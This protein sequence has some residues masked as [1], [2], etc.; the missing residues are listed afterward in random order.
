MLGRR[1]AED[2]RRFSLMEVEDV[3]VQRIER[4]DGAFGKRCTSSS[5]RRRPSER[6]DESAAALGAEVDREEFLGGP[7][8]EFRIAKCV[9]C[10]MPTAL[11]GHASVRHVRL[12]ATGMRSFIPDRD[13]ATHA[14]A[15][16]WAWHTDRI[17]I[18]SP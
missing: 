14:H 13:G 10:A 17:V 5:V 3:P 16:P 4:G 9:M 1:F 8:R 7:W 6:A 2:R 15:K 11:R 12:V 18:S